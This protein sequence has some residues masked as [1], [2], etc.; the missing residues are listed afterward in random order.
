MRPE[1]CATRADYTVK[2]AISM[3]FEPMGRVAPFCWHKSAVQIWKNAFRPAIRDMSASENHFILLMLNKM[4]KGEE[5]NYTEYQITNWR[6]E[7]RDGHTEA[8]D[9]VQLNV[10][11]APERAYLLRVYATEDDHLMTVWASEPWDAFGKL[12]GGTP[13]LRKAREDYPHYWYELLLD[14]ADE[15]RW[16]RLAEE[17]RRGKEN[18]NGSEQE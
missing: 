17:S 9:L 10:E 4:T 8:V 2:G 16:Q 5:G 12:S 13:T 7:Y 18:E 14:E 6:F 3:K 11:G 1:F 15:H